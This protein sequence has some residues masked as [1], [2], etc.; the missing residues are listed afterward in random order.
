MNFSTRRILF[1]GGH[2]DDIELG[3]G[4]FLHKIAGY[5]EVRCITLSDN[6]RNPE[7]K[8]IVSEHLASL[9]TLGVLD[10]QVSIG[11]FETRKF[12]QQRQEILEYL[13]HHRQAFKPD[14]VFVH[15]KADIHQ[16]HN[17]VTEEALRAFR[18]TSVLGFDVV[19][20]SYGFFPTSWLR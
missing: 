3:C 5:S 8:N 7:L 2:P 9:K 11:E 16:D 6:S 4:A 12:P 13:F 19:R 15:T 10:E 14:M 18:G 17:V 20:S 1:L